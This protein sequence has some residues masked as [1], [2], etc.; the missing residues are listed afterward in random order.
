MD[1][2][3]TT[4]TKA[5]SGANSHDDML[6]IPKWNRMCLQKYIWDSPNSD[7]QKS[8][9]VLQRHYFSCKLINFNQCC[10]E[11]SCYLSI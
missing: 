6:S 4:D 7:W 2:N 11:F 1:T 3:L 10:R 5:T 8:A 9:P